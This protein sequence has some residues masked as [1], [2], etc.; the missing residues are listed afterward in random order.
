MFYRLPER[1]LHDLPLKSYIKRPENC[2]HQ[3]KILT[4][5]EE[6]LTTRVN[7]SRQKKKKMSQQE[8]NSK[9]KKKNLTMGERIFTRRKIL[10][11]GERI[12]MTEEKFL[13]WKKNSHNTRKVKKTTTIYN[14][15]TSIHI[16]NQTAF[17]CKRA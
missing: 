7:F 16:W 5:R 11:M 13:W 12:F 4:T 14:I 3:W 10:T 15:I 17:S 8:K 9:S 2:H 6:I 1:V